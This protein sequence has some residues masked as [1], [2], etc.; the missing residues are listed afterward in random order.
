MIERRGELWET[1]SNQVLPS[2]IPVRFPGGVRVR[3]R[4]KVRMRLRGS[5]MGL[6]RVGLEDEFIADGA[7]EIDREVVDRQ[8]LDDDREDGEDVPL[9]LDTPKHSDGQAEVDRIRVGRI[10]L[11][12][13]PKI[14]SKSPATKFMPWQ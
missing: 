13:T 10:G 14:K 6:G 7:F 2:K 5:R 9:R 3:V 11:A 8:L 12:S 4:G 1:R